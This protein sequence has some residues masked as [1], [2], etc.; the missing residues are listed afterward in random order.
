MDAD[1]GS[2]SLSS[3][4]EGVCQAQQHECHCGFHY[5][6]LRYVSHGM[7]GTMCEDCKTRTVI[8]YL[9]IALSYMC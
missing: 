8:L 6:E 9:C 2:S 5:L 7:Q 1:G 3:P 4:C